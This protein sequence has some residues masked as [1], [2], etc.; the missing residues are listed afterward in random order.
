LKA[1]KTIGCDYFTAL[2]ERILSG[3][4]KEKKDYGFPI[5]GK[6]DLSLFML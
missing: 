4:G 5:P 3:F 6:N 1:K 2:K